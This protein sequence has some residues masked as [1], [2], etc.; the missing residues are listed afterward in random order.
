M[1]NL[2][3]PSTSMLVPVTSRLLSLAMNTTILAMSSPHALLAH[4]D[5]LRA[6]NQPLLVRSLRDPR[7]ALKEVGLLE[8][9]KKVLK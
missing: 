4:G 2:Y 5:G 6:G 1:V 7:Y 8:I 3:P 9:M